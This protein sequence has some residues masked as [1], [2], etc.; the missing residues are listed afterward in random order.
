VSKFTEI[1]SLYSIKFNWKIPTTL[2]AEKRP[3][4]S[5]RIQQTWALFGI[6]KSMYLCSLSM[7][8]YVRVAL[9]PQDFRIACHSSHSILSLAGTSQFVLENLCRFGR[10]CFCLSW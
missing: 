4:N 1:S 7:I 8:L 9:R 3:G 5:W 6:W 10:G 2:M